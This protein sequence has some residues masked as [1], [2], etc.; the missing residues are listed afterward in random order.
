VSSC[1]AADTVSIL[2]LIDGLDLVV[3]IEALLVVVA[4]DMLESRDGGR[5][6]EK[7][8]VAGDCNLEDGPEATIGDDTEVLPGLE[9]AAPC[10]EAGGVPFLPA[11]LA[12]PS[13]GCSLAP[14]T[15]ARRRLYRPLKPPCTKSIPFASPTAEG[16][17]GTVKSS[18]VVSVSEREAVACIWCSEGCR[19]PRLESPDMATIAERGV[20]SNAR[21]QAC[22]SRASRKT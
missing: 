14:P 2:V 16:A 7:V 17:G 5:A 9:L 10:L 13:C 12:C 20:E 4:L 1:R 6:S 15:E 18:K 19:E 3:C 11:V 22:G 21:R 8:A